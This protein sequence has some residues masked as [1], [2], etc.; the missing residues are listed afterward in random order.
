L[1]RHLLKLVWSRKRANALLLIEIFASFLV[2]FAVSSLGAAAV[3]RWR[4]PLGFDYHDVWT[5]R[6]SFPPQSA[7]RAEDAPEQLVAVESMMREARSLDAVESIAAD[8]MP[9]YGRG[10]WISSINVNGHPL[11]TM[12]DDVSDDYAK[13]MRIPVLR[14]R[15]FSPDDDA[16]AEKRIVIDADV[17]RTLF[18][19]VD[20]AANQVIETGEKRFSRVIGVIAPFRK[21]GEFS[22]QKTNMVFDRISLATPQKGYAEHGVH[23][24][25]GENRHVPRFLMIRVRPGTPADF[26][27]TLIKRLH[28]VAPEYRIRIQHMEQTRVFMNR[29]YAAP[30]VV[31][32][33]VAAFL[34]IMVALGLSGVLWQTVTRRTRE[35]GLRRAMGATGGQVH[36]QILAEVALLSTGALTAGVIVVVQLPIVAG[37]QFVTPAS[38]AFGLAAALATI[39]AITLLCGVY[40]SWL[41]G[42]VQ[43][44]EALHHE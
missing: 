33:I 8:S 27:E 5:G 39:Y 25:G 24:V 19:S 28:D 37:N 4:T 2:V 11:D 29:V 3:M 14:G 23:A 6:I 18:G 1:I 9:P 15:W 13:T 41:A 36:R 17:A 22:P 40:P 35:I 26:E 12:R 20:A 10:E 42:R 30:A 16:S 32:A 31:L 21:G 44:A 38:F 43:P 7:M 34:I